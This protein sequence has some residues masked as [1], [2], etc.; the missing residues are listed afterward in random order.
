MEN[1]FINEANRENDSKMQTKTVLGIK[2]MVF[3]LL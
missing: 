2:N 3:T 1:E